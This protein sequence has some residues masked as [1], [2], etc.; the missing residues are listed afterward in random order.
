MSESDQR[1]PSDERNAWEGPEVTP[2]TSSKTDKAR[3]ARGDNWERDAITQL[4]FAAVT[5]QR[6]A[7]R[8]SIFFKLLIFL[9][10]LMIFWIYQGKQ[11]EESS[12]SSGEHTAL[13][14]VQGVIADNADASADNIITSLRSAFKDSGTRGI[15]LRINS[16]GGSPVQSGYIND[17]IRRLREEYP[18]IPLYAVVTDICA[19]GGY[20][21]AVAADRI[22]ADKAS[23]VGSIG[24][25]MGGLSTFGFTEAMKKLGI[26]RRLLAAGDDKAMLDPFSPLKDEE[27]EHTRRLL[28]NIHQQF[29]Q[30]V[31]QGRG[32]RL[33][34]DDNML[35]NGLYWTGQQ[36]LELGLIDGLNSSSQVARDVIGAEKI[37]DFTR[38]PSPF[39]Q[40]ADRLGVVMVKTIASMAETSTHKLW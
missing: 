19:S 26:E 38:H 22:Y 2:P 7:R 10:L 4:A 39:E 29:I 28:N 14:E 13:V 20:Y 36:S 31:K 5:E 21:I 3:A 18:N 23:I 37:V 16:P 1:P 40:F 17:E 25:R 27:V 6:R 30:V 32:D 24:V 33:K 34:G 8:W 15:I 12:L 35:F 9:Y 11:L